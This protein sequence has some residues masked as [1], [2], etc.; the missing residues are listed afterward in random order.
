V[1]VDLGSQSVAVSATGCGTCTNR[2]PWSH[3]EDGDIAQMNVALAFV[4]GLD[5]SLNNVEHGL[6]V[7]H[8]RRSL[9]AVER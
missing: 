8:R 5:H 9:P 1:D 2:V 7:G 6:S 3:V 4:R